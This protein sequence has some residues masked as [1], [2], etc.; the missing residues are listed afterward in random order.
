M[1]YWEM[2]LTSF[3]GISGCG[4]PSNEMVY[5]RISSNRI[6]SNRISCNGTSC[7]GISCNETPCNGILGNGISGN[8]YLP[9][10][11]Q[12][13]DYYAKENQAMEYQ[14]MYVVTI[15]LRNSTLNCSDDVQEARKDARNHERKLLHF[16]ELLLLPH[17][18]VL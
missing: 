11:L 1:E 7:N 16:N 3:N 12:D 10:K 15:E 9:L 13:T 2:E 14:A 18:H 8:E 6:S 17:I 5:N 4:I